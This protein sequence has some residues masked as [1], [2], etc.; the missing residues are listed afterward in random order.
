M[1]IAIL[2]AV[3]QNRIVASFHAGVLSIQGIPEA[4]K[5]R[6]MAGMGNLDQLRTGMPA[7][8][9]GGRAD[10]GQR[11]ARRRASPVQTAPACRCAS[12]RRICWN[13][14]AAG[15]TSLQDWPA[16]NAN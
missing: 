8:A 12:M 3:L 4:V 2:G 7:A 16:N 13:I 5:Q 9:S 15:T 6:I 14:I 1:G 10:D 11:R